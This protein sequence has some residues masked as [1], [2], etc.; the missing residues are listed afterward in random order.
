MQGG[1]EEQNFHG[2]RRLALLQ[3]LRLRSCGSRVLSRFSIETKV[4]GSVV[5]RLASKDGVF[6]LRP[7]FVLGPGPAFPLALQ[8]LRVRRSLA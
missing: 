5:P 2:A 6:L 1:W 7:P 8:A 4:R 3:L